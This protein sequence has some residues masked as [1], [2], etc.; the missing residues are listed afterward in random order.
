MNKNINLNKQLENIGWVV[1]IN[2]SFVTLSYIDREL[3]V[4][5]EVLTLKKE[6]LIN[7]SKEEIVAL[8]FLYEVAKEDIDYNNLLKM[9]SLITD[10]IDKNDLIKILFSN[11]LQDEKEAKIKQLIKNYDT[12]NWST[13]KPILKDIITTTKKDSVIFNELYNE[14]NDISDKFVV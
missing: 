10:D 7:L 1:T 9:K 13:L 11:H 2:P 6:T 3:E 4:A 12:S 5:N 14:L 8:K